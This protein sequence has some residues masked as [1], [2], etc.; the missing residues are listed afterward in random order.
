[1]S[2]LFVWLAAGFYDSAVQPRLSE[3]IRTYSGV[4]V[5]TSP[6]FWEVVRGPGAEDDFP[7]ESGLIGF[8]RDLVRPGDRVTLVGGGLGV[9][10]VAAAERVGRSGSVTVFEAH[11]GSCRK[12]AETLRLNDVDASVDIRHAV[13]DSIDDPVPDGTEI[14]AAEHLPECDVLILD[15]EGAEL[16]ILENLDQAPR[17]LIVEAH[18]VYG[19][20]WESVAGLIEQRGYEVLDRVVAESAARRQC[21]RDGIWVLATESTSDSRRPNRPGA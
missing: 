6:S 3:R 5:K 11:H 9:S 12:V 18:G 13:V 19:A 10:T 15:C 17:A 7:Y 21:L 20:P 14:L 8:I 4:R 16:A 1:M 2:D